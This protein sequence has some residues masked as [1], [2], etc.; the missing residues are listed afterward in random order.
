MEINNLKQ[1]GG[2]YRMDTAK[3]IERDSSIGKIGQVVDSSYESICGEMR[4]ES[5]TQR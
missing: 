1:S 2:V 5:G 3:R 4:Y